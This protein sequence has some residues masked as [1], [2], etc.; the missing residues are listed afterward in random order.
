MCSL[1]FLYFQDA[2]Q[3]ARQENGMTGY[4]RLDAP[5]TSERIRMACGDAI[6]KICAA[7]EPDFHPKGSW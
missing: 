1:T 5:A 4:Y 3:Y 7:N 2:I 6:A